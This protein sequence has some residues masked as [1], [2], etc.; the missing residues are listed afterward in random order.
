M[1]ASISTDVLAIVALCFTLCLAKRNPVVNNYK[2]KIYISVSVITIILLILEITTILMEL[3]SSNKLVIPHRI[4]NIMGFSL[5]PVIPFIFLFFNNKGKR[6][7][8]N[9]ILAI[10]LYF[11]AFMCILS[12]KTG[13]IFLVDA[14]NQYS[15]GNLFLLPMIISMFYFVLM[16]IAVNKGTIEY[17]IDDKKVLNLIQFYIYMVFY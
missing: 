15:R 8:H 10:P 9:S 6:N 17:E 12:Y 1:T 3:S 4:V 5:S 16:I 14:L 11:N 7:F 13:W 2:N